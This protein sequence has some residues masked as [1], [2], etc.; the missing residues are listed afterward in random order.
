MPGSQSGG[1]VVD[2]Q[3]MRSTVG[4]PPPV[5]EAI[6]K[7]VSPTFG[8]SV[9]FTSCRSLLFATP[10][11]NRSVPVIVPA[12][13]FAPRDWVTICRLPTL[14]RPL[15][16][17]LAWL[18]NK[19]SID[20]LGLVKGTL[21]I[22]DIIRENRQDGDPKQ[23]ALKRFVDYPELGG[24]KLAP[25]LLSEGILKSPIHLNS[26]LSVRGIQTLGIRPGRCNPGIEISNDRPYLRAPI[27]VFSPSQWGATVAP[28]DVMTDIRNL[29][30]LVPVIVVDL[31][32]LSSAA[33]PIFS[34]AV[35]E[36]TIEKGFSTEGQPPAGEIGKKIVIFDPRRQIILKNVPDANYLVVVASL[37]MAFRALTDASRP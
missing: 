2:P 18:G 36:L 7:A 26:P 15:A 3:E 20:T 21:A 13:Q 27:C 8:A 30:R 10:G 32:E 35:A 37:E 4:G 31:S 11:T 23:R 24:G 17:A 34:R 25:G 6:H 12:S 1:P 9:S 28:K 14:A 33:G 5:V 29:S 22:V 16:K 19:L